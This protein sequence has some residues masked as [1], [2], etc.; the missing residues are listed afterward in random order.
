MSEGQ[1]FCGNILHSEQESPFFEEFRSVR[2]QETGVAGPRK[3]G[4]H[5]GV[6]VQVVYRLVGH[7][8][9]LDDTSV[10]LGYAR[11][12]LD[13]LLPIP[14]SEIMNTVGDI[15]IFYDDDNSRVP[16]YGASGES[17][18]ESAVRAVSD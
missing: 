3:P 15:V 11:K 12:Y 7:N 14:L 6:A 16:R 1:G 5:L 10:Q 2:G 17:C 4:V 8:L 13:S 9:A 18:E